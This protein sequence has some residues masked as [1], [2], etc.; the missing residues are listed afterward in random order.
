MLLLLSI[1][2]RQNRDRQQLRTEVPMFFFARHSRVTS[3]PRPSVNKMELPL[4][5]SLFL[6]LLAC[7]WATTDAAPSKSSP[8]AS[9]CG[10]DVNRNEFFEKTSMR[11]MIQSIFSLMYRAA[12]RLSLGW[13]MFTSFHVWCFTF[14]DFLIFLTNP[15]RCQVAI[16]HFAQ[17]LTMTSVGWRPW[18]STIME[19]SN[20]KIKWLIFVS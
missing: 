14:F 5:I 18:T 16:E 9:S 2:V 7:S 19:V 3:V 1:T 13:S 20:I 15:L 12:L 8:R 11:H 6:V 4:I 10:Y 17:I